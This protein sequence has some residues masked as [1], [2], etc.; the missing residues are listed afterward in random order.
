MC[1]KI[2]KC[3]THGDKY[4]REIYQNV[5]YFIQIRY[6]QSLIYWNWRHNNLDWKTNMV[7]LQ[8][9]SFKRYKFDVKY[10]NQHLK[11]LQVFIWHIQWREILFIVIHVYEK[12]AWHLQM[13]MLCP[14]GLSNISPCYLL[15]HEKRTCRHNQVLWSLADGY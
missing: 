15:C 6:C 11:T 2:F 8:I 3:E 1:S 4:K 7:R 10:F 9:T 13:H 14:S 12:L 5:W